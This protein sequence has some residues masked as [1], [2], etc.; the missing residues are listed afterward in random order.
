MKRAKR[1]VPLPRVLVDG[2]RALRAT[3]TE[4][5]LLPEPPWQVKPPARGPVRPK[6][7]ARWRAVCFSMTV[8]AGET[9]YTCSYE[10]QEVSVDVELAMVLVGAQT[11]APWADR[12][13]YVGVEHSQEQFRDNSYGI[14]TRVQ[15]VQEA[16]VPSVDAV[17]EHVSDYTQQAIFA[18][19]L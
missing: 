9:W 10:E 7:E 14:G 4:V 5:R 3:T 19:A 6:R 11:A 1:W 17:M 16:L 18:F 15:L 13:T 2:Y 12:D 8:R